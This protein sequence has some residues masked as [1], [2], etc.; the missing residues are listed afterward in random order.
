[1]WKIIDFSEWLWPENWKKKKRKEEEKKEK[2]IEL[3]NKLK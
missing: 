1:M 2:H 3:E